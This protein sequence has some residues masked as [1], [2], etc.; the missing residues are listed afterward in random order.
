M[1][2]AEPAQKTVSLQPQRAADRNDIPGGG[3]WGRDGFRE[4][5]SFPKRAGG[6]LR[7]D[8]V[9]HRS[10]PAVGTGS[11]WAWSPPDIQH[12]RL[13]ER[14]AGVAPSFVFFV[15]VDVLVVLAGR[16]ERICGDLGSAIYRTKRVGCPVVI[17]DWS[18]FVQKKTVLSFVGN[19]PPHVLPGG[20]GMGRKIFSYTPWHNTKLVID[21]RFPLND[22]IFA[23]RAP[24][25]ETSV[26][27]DRFVRAGWS[28]ANREG[29]VPSRQAGRM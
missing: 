21:L 29:H 17:E 9:R 7:G 1:P 6:C 14:G 13:T 3:L 12:G 5:A 27:P 22:Q 2:H 25:W 11:L 16:A 10:A 24:V 19:P 4:Q 23:L 15:R 18:H 20:L 26:D 28:A 8:D